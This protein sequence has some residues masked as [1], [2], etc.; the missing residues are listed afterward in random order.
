MFCGET[1]TISL[2]CPFVCDC[3]EKASIT[4]GQERV[5]ILEKE[6]DDCLID[7]DTLSVTLTQEE[8]RMFD[9]D[10]YI[11]DIQLNIVIRGRR[12]ISEIIQVP[13]K[14]C[15]RGDIL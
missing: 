4:F 7:G 10:K 14:F 3:I 12:A 5:L 11:V 2:Q 1:P 15:Y 6:L 8:T 13:V 9:P